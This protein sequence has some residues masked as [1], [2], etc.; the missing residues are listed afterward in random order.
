MIEPK[1]T[2]EPLARFVWRTARAFAHHLGRSFHQAGYDVTPEQW[3]ILRNLWEQDGQSQQ[4]LAHCSVKDKASITRLI[5]GLER[6]NL[7]VRIPDQHDRRQKRIYLTHRGKELQKPLSEIV[8]Q[9]QDVAQMNINEA[10]LALCK[11]VLQQVY[12]NLNTPRSENP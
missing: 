6:R 5:D 1:S 9:T 8:K 4:Q 2:D 12:D 10:D 11:A 3:K 7:V